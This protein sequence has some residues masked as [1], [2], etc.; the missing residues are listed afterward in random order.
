MLNVSDIQQVQAV[1]TSRGHCRL[2]VARL[3]NRYILVA[4]PMLK[5]QEESLEASQGDVKKHFSV[6]T[7]TM[8]HKSIGL[9][10][11]TF[12]C[13]MKRHGIWLRSCKDSH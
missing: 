8:S 11:A 6:K 7:H 2:A 10:H 4:G 12:E 1:R 5:E 9:C 3:T 13:S